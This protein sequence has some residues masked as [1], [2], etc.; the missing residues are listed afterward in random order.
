MTG[1]P[2]QTDASRATATIGLLLDP[3][4]VLFFRDGRPFGEASYGVSTTPLP[5]TLAGA[6]RTNLLRHANC[7]FDKLGKAMRDTSDFRAAVEAGGAPAWIADLV[8]RGPWFARDTESTSGVELLL[9]VP[10][11]LHVDKKKTAPAR[12]GARRSGQDDGEAKLYRIRPVRSETIPGWR[13]AARRA[14][15]ERPLAPLWAKHAARTEPAHGYLTTRGF[16]SFLQDDRSHE[17]TSVENTGLVKND[18]VFAFDRRTGIGIDPKTLHADDG[19]IYGASFLSLKPKVCLYASVVVPAA[20]LRDAAEAFERVDTMA[21][22]GEGRRVHVRVVSGADRPKAPAHRD[23]APGSRERPLVVLTTPG[24][25]EARCR[26]APQ[27]LLANGNLTSAAVSGNVPVSGWDL[28]RG[29]PKPTRFAVAAGAVYFLQ[30]P[31]TNWPTS[32]CDDERD[33]AQGWGCYVRGVW[34]DE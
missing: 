3:L 4:D 23:P 19:K 5:Q 29:G 31:L 27:C 26:W 28:A 25:F 16:E 13:H 2:S 17:K 12:S 9:P 34:T 11:V 21:F 18:D 6:V 33:R 22:G 32:L 8:V 30:E 15:I 14:G 20:A 10:H 7:D 1:I 24:L